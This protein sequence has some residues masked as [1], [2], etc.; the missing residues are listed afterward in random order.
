MDKERVAQLGALSQQISECRRCPRLVAWR[1]QV[2]REKRRAYRDEVYWGRPV[3]GFGDPHAR[4]LIVGLAPGAH[5]AN[6]TGRVFTG[7]DSGHWLYGALYEHGFSNQATA[8][9]RADGLELVG[10]YINNACRCAPPDN[11][12]TAEEF[13][14]CRPYFHAELD[15]LTG[16]R[17]V[18][19]LGKLA[20]DAY[21]Q[22][23][24]ARGV[25]TRGMAFGHGREYQLPGG[26]TLLCSYHPS[27][28]NTNTGVL[29]PAMWHAIFA[30]CRALVDAPHPDGAPGRPEG[31]R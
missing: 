9:H 2:A 30:R 11:K 29:T 17:V 10:A 7:D 28:Q 8:T 6:R 16:V 21:K 15:L 22:Y 26:V 25:S 4:L 31:D 20:F 18:L 12:P 13:A 14:A 5:G 24:S 3:P 23:L 27:R 1:E 19:A